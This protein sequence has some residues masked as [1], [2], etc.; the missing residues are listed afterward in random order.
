MTNLPSPRQ[1]QYFIALEKYRHFGKAASACFVTQPAF[2][3]AIRELENTLGLKLVDRTNKKVTITGL[4]RDIATQCRLVLRDLEDLVDMARVNTSPLTGK[5]NIGVIPTVAPFLLP[6]LLPRLRRSFPDLRLIL[7][8]D[9]TMR[10]YDGLMEGELDIIL[11]ALPF[12]LRNVE[13][14]KLFTD[15][16]HLAYRSG[17][18]LLDPADYHVEQMPSESVLLMEDGHCLRDQALTACKLRNVDK[19]SPV[20]A[21][22]LL[23]LI[24]MVDAD[25]G[26][27]YLPEMAMGSWLLKNTRVRTV[28]LKSAPHRDI[29]LVWR[30]GSTRGGEF[31]ELGKFIRDNR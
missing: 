9:Q 21:N 12:E 15:P 27:T 6:P 19:V 14:M 4:G 31:R 23:T 30:K 25:L 13:I 16:F 10:I 2:S 7:H 11:I 26:V 17:T 8:E 5:L 28:P 24:E 22:S 29:G 3:V 20:T 1:L 18:A